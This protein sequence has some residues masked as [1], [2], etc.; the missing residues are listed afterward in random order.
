MTAGMR[1]LWA[2][3]GQLISRNRFLILVIT[4]RMHLPGGL[5]ALPTEPEWEHACGSNACATLESG[6]YGPVSSLR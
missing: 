6:F 3:V 1:P 4:R 2:D 5:G